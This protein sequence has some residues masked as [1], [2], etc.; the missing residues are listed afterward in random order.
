MIARLR[1]S[2]CID[3]FEGIGYEPGAC[4]L[5]VIKIDHVQLAS[6]YCKIKKY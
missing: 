3:Q 2:A 5:S 4:F 6:H 1:L